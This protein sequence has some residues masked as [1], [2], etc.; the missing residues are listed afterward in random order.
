MNDVLLIVA[1]RPVTV[2]DLLPGLGILG[3]VAVL[4]VF[5]AVWR[6]LAR[7]RFGEAEALE[8]ARHTE[9]RLA[10]MMRL[11]A[12]MA[13]RMQAMA[14]GLG[15]RQQDLARAVTERLDGLT[16]RLGRTL[17]ETSRATNENLGRLN[18]R[19][20]VIDKAQKTLGDLTGEMLELKTILSDKQAR[21]AYGQGRMEAI[22]QDALPPSAYQFQ[23]TLSN[24]SRPDCLVLLPNGAAPLAID[25]KF[26]LEGWTAFR[27]AGTPEDLARAEAQLRRDVSIHIK[28]IRTKYLISG[29]TQDTAFLFVPSES[30]FA[31]L[32]EHFDDLIQRAHRAR[33]IIVSPS[34][35]LLSIQVVQAVLRDHRM[36]EEAHRIQAEVGLLLDDVDRLMERVG[37][38]G[39]HFA[40]A[41]KDVEQIAV[42]ADKI[43]RRG[44]RIEEMDLGAPPAPDAALKAAAPVVR[45]VGE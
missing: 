13:G 5:A 33:V 32:N 35:L 7:R 17:V 12:E 40:Q 15:H 29:E 26:P 22:I 37:K 44:A 14:E 3:L 19:I 28:D 41:T 18:E 1:G 10:E 43:V 27:D 16:H 42:S 31:D 21:G 30:L 45:L 4:L 8:Q 23:A 2:A 24:G 34:L 9:D 38:L 6:A 39:S 20:A 25:A 11:Q 36:R